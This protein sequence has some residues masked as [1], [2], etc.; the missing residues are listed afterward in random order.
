MQDIID[1]VTTL[2]QANV[3]WSMTAGPIW[4]GIGFLV[5]GLIA[6]TSIIIDNYKR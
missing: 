4:W 1:G 6:G 2:S 5:V 3:D